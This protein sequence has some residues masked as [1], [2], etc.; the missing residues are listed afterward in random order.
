MSSLLVAA[1]VELIKFNDVSLS[2]PALN[3]LS[4]ILTAILLLFIASG[5]EPIPS[6]IATKYFPSSSFV[7]IWLSPETGESAFVLV[8]TLFVQYICHPIN[9]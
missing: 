6:L 1:S 5:P 7:S 9:R 4:N 2:N 3:N 8:A